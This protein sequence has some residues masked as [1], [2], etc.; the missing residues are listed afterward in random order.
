[1]HTGQNI[2][3]R[4]QELR[5]IERKILKRLHDLEASVPKDLHYIEEAILE[6][7]RAI[8]GQ[9]LKDLRDIEDEI[10]LELHII[11]EIMINEWHLI[12]QTSLDKSLISQELREI[13]EIKAW[14][15]EALTGW[16]RKSADDGKNRELPEYYTLKKKL[17][18]TYNKIAAHRRMLTARESARKNA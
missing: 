17:G 16:G 10:L 8:E 18:E 4:L 6:G 12:E 9:L 14:W 5:S 3:Q 15:K 7:F 13:A 1:M 2:E 11:E